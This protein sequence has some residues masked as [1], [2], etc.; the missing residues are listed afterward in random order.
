LAI[1][2]RINYKEPQMA[3]K[4][5]RIAFIA[6][7]LA[8][9]GTVAAIPAEAQVPYQNYYVEPGPSPVGAELYVSPR[10][11]PA[12]VGHTYITYEPCA[13]HQFLHQ[14]GRIYSH[15]NPGGGCTTT[16][17]LW[18][19]APLLNLQPLPPLGKTVGRF[20]NFGR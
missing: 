1:S 16:F 13:P 11:T 2:V 3:N 18:R 6:L 15:N 14:H 5:I 8:I 10:P 20:L 7:G 9:I 19:N 17:V 4:L 12:Y